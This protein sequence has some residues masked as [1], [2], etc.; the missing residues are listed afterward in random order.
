MSVSAQDIAK[1]EH[2]R[3][4]AR[5]EF[6]KAL[7]EQFCRKIKT[8][9]QLGQREC[10]LTVP[11]FLVGFPRYDLPTTVRYMCR[12]LQRLGYIVNLV[13][14]LDIKVW[15]KKPPAHQMLPEEVEEV[16]L[17]SLVNLQKMAST[18]RKKPR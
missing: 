15:W 14:P 10:M 13:G 4:S 12:Q 3:K 1:M 8:S 9:V 2:A 17:P 7:L 5:K 18:L 11:V 6:Y 16:E